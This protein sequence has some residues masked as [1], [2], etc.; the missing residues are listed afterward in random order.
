M[1]LSD[2]NTVEGQKKVAL[3]GKVCYNLL[4]KDKET[5]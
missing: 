2:K 5:Q 1:T 3:I 4:D